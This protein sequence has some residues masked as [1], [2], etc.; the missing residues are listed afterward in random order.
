M[1]TGL[2]CHLCKI[3]ITEFHQY[4]AQGHW[5]ELQ[6]MSLKRILL[7]SIIFKNHGLFATKSP[8]SNYSYIMCTWLIPT[9]KIPDR[10]TTSVRLRP[11]AWNL[12]V[13]LPT[14]SKGPGNIVLAP[15]WLA[16]SP[17]LLPNKTFHDG[18]PLCEVRNLLINF[19]VYFPFYIVY[20][21]LIL[22]KRTESRA[23]M[24]RMSAQETTPL[25]ELSTA[26]LIASITSN[27]LTELLFGK[28]VFSPSLP[29]SKT[30]ASHP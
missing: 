9:L 25:H 3:M 18:P 2:S 15:L 6:G 14:V 20:A 13:M 7:I 24:V 29:S 17:S 11:T 4:S 23:A 12:R 10:D 8:K 26:L 22:T 28:A 21:L 1:P 19:Q 16:T 30:D 5:V 27:P